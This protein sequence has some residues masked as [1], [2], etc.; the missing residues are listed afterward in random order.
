M[1]LFK[2]YEEVRQKVNRAKEQEQEQKDLRDVV[3]EQIENTVLK[4][5]KEPLCEEVAKPN[6]ATKEF[7][8][9]VAAAKQDQVAAIATIFSTTANFFRGDGKTPWDNIVK[10]K[11]T[12]GRTS[13][14][15]SSPGSKARQWQ[16]G[17]TA[18]HSCSQQFLQTM[19]Q[20]SK[21]ST[22]PCYV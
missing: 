15:R 17:A 3:L 6:E 22:S 14:R 2:K 1:G 9:A 5:D 11:R 19:Q 8:A 12:R 13:V 16:P 7:K 10:P 4:S 21:N 18:T 20:S